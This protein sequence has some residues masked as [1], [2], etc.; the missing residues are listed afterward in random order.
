M[1]TWELTEIA[2]QNRYDATNLKIAGISVLRN[3]YII[4]RCMVTVVSNEK[5][6]EPGYAK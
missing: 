2:I 6:R 3:Q 5:L 4:L 1:L